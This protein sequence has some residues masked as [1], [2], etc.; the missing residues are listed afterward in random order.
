MIAR[1]AGQ[2]G[3]AL[4]GDLLQSPGV[5]DLKNATALNIRVVLP[6]DR[7]RTGRGR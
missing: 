4:L 6:A 7:S 5:A 1:I 3:N 2:M